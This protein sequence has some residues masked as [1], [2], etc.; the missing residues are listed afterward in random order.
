VS[1]ASETVHIAK[2]P[3]GRPRFQPTKEQRQLVEMAVAVGIPQAQIQT[4][5]R[6]QSGK[7][8]TQHTLSKH[9]GEEIQNATAK[10]TIKV[11]ASLY[12]NAVVENNVAAQIFWLKTRAGWRE[13]FDLEMTIKKLAEE[14]SDDELLRVAAG[15]SDRTSEAP[16]G[17]QEPTVVR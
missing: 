11:G 13:R 8:I 7:P 6:H 3:G 4:L 1:D 5:I 15:G 9:F 2:N 17:T 14:L 16:S 10:A 12:H